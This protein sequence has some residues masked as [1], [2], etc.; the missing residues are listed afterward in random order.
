L[1]RN[2]ARLTRVPDDAVAR[3]AAVPGTW[4]LLA[5]SEDWCGDAVNTLPHVA[6]L[7]D[8]APNLDLRVLAR[9]E[10]L[11]LMDAHLTGIARAIPV[12]IVY[13]AEFVERGWWGPRPTAAPAVGARPGGAGAGQNAA[14]SARSRVV[15]ARPRAHHA[16]RGDRPARTGRGGLTVARSSPGGRVARS[17]WNP[18]RARAYDGGRRPPPSGG[19]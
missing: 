10:N 8:Q 15:R 18:D 16:R 2:A 11:D 17:R 5:L 3:A 13:D 4:H 19:G 7:A 9:D 6:R 14:L 12:V 1:W